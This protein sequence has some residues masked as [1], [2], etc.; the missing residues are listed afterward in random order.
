[1]DL[2]RA[3]VFLHVVG[4]FMFV[5]G[6]GVS[7]FVV[8]Q[9]RKERDRG[10]LAAI[11]DLSGWSLGVAGVGLLILLVAGIAAGIMLG[12]FG[13]LWIWVSLVLLIVIGGLM[14]PVGGTYLRKLR[15]ALGQPMRGAKPGDPAPVAVSDGELVALQASNAPE[16]LLA[17]GAVGFVVI[18]YLMM[19]RPF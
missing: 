7:M 17:I 8:F 4:A 1:M 18:L 14:T 6:H 13:K 3:I 10:R 5:A 15:V 2:T 16:L 12:S 19:F 11:L 9:A